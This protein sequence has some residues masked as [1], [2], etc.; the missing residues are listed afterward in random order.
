M[1]SALKQYQSLTDIEDKAIYFERCFEKMDHT[2]TH[3]LIDSF[4][5]EPE[6]N[7]ETYEG[8]Y[9]ALVAKTDER[10]LSQY[11]ELH[12]QKHGEEFKF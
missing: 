3:D 9:N 12:L 1:L 10:F 4:S 5:L 11:S 7:P 6:V 2:I 8:D